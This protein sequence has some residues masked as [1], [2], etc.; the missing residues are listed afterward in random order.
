MSVS[1]AWSESS[2]LTGSQYPAPDVTNRRCAERRGSRQSRRF[3]N[4][5]S[6][7]KI[8]W[9]Q[10]KL[11]QSGHSSAPVALP[12]Y[13]RTHCRHGPD[14]HHLSAHQRERWPSLQGHP[15][16]ER[17]PGHG[18]AEHEERRV[19]RR[20]KGACSITQRAAPA[21]ASASFPALSL[22]KKSSVASGNCIFC[23]ARLVASLAGHK[24]R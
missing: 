12:C 8:N 9:E 1:Q 14:L 13:P 15:G 11:H 18:E 2:Q 10:R 21:S 24:E 6:P 4:P 17:H 3:L 23:K 16:G 20:D 22:G 19:D 7:L 5:G